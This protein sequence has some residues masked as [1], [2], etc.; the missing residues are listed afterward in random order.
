MYNI[1]MLSTVDTSF[2]SGK[3]P[4]LSPEAVEKAVSYGLPFSLFGFATVFFVLIVIMLVVVIF[5]KV[6]GSA[7]NKPVSSKKQET[8]AKTEAVVKETK[9]VEAAPADDNGSV[10]AAI[11]AA[12]S[13]FRVSNGQSAGGFRVVSFKK[14]K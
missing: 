4:T 6:F 8:T 3:L 10:V 13:A 5:G 1:Q 7:K 12:I 14:R 9:P 2:Y 11:M